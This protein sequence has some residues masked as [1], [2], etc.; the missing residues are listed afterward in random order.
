MKK[1]FR[2]KLPLL[3]P[4]LF[5]LA[6]A[7]WYCTPK[8]LMQIDAERITCISIFDGT[9]GEGVDVTDPEELQALADELNSV[10]MKP[11]KPSLGY[12]GYRF[13]IT[14]YTERNGKTGAEKTF[15]VNSAETVRIDPF[16]YEV[17]D[18][19]IDVSLLEG[20]FP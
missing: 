7:L 16:F 18:G 20:L 8:P 1:R 9:Q 12:M 17:T 6:A 5:L 14:V 2:R 4:G 10:R 19:E 13:R 3:L 11:T 15:I